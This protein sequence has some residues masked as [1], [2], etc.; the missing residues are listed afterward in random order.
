MAADPLGDR[1]VVEGDH[2]HPRRQALRQRQAVGLGDD[3]QQQGEVD[4]VAPQPVDQRPR[5]VVAVHPHPGEPPQAVEQRRVAAAEGAEAEVRNGLRRQLPDH[6]LEDQRPFVR[7]HLADVGGVADGPRPRRRSAARRRHRRLNDP[8]PA[9]VEP[10]EELQVAV[11]EELGRVD[12]GGCGGEEPAGDLPPLVLEP[13]VHRPVL[14]Q[15]A[16][17]PLAVARVAAEAQPRALQQVGAGAEEAEVVDR[18]D[19]RQPRALQLG[20]RAEGDRRQPLDVQGARPH[21]GGGARH[22]ALEGQEALGHRGLWRP[23]LDPQRQPPP[24]GHHLQPVVVVVWIEQ[25]HRPALRLALDAGEE[26]RLHPAQAR[27]GGGGEE[28]E[29]RDRGQAGGARP[30]VDGAERTPAERFAQTIGDPFAQRG[31]PLR[32]QHAAGGVEGERAVAVHAASCRARWIRASS[33]AKRA[34]AASGE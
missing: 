18:E 17:A 19:G 2:R 1:T 24:R 31:E 22:R 16:G 26:L 20:E 27:R 7:L 21:L 12:D 14:G 10:R 25:G 33:R 28:V 4:P 3:R 23:P 34:P 9:G 6:L 32:P 30:A 8:L 29:H 13:Q 15:A 11:A 5:P